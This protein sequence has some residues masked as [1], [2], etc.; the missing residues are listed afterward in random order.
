MYIISLVS[1]LQLLELISWG[2]DIIDKNIHVCNKGCMKD[3]YQSELICI[4]FS[5]FHRAQR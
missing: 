3:L 5:T 4:V 1:E 2:I